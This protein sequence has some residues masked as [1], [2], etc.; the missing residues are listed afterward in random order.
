MSPKEPEPI[1]RPILY[2]LP[3]RSS[4]VIVELSWVGLGLVE[5]D[6][7]SSW[8]VV[9]IWHLAAVERVDWLSKSLK[10]G[11]MKVVVA[12]E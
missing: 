5:C 12:K 11:W 7:E 8:G 10:G 9:E 4:M 2:L 6:G 3:T 1:L